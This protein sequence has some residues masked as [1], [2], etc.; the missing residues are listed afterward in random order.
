M[1]LKN[2]L[3]RNFNL[4]KIFDLFSIPQKTP[5]KMTAHKNPDLKTLFKKNL[6]K[7]I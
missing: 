4:S 1:K 6:K 3:H 7:E 5:S 2:H